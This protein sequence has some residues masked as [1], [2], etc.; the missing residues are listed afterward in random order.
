[1]NVIRTNEKEAIIIN[2]ETTRET[3]VT[4]PLICQK[5]P[6]LEEAM[7]K[8]IEKEE[9]RKCKIKDD[10]YDEI[11]E[12]YHISILFVLNAQLIFEDSDR[13]WMI[14]IQSLYSGNKK[15]IEGN[16]EQLKEIVIKKD[17]Y[18]GFSGHFIHYESTDRKGEEQNSL[19]CACLVK[20]T[21]DKKYL[22]E[23]RLA[24][25]ISD[26]V[27]IRCSEIEEEVRNM[28][29]GKELQEVVGKGALKELNPLTSWR[30]AREFRYRLI[31]EL[32]RKSLEI[33]I[34]KSGGFI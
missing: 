13:E 3:L 9:N 32:T 24:Y 2:A 12:S 31:E 23:I 6:V 7:K 28:K 8:I 20:L 33:S 19:G 21:E 34:T 25:T 15:S 22:E 29:V 30:A 1:M 27:P 10:I 17:D 11:Q 16:K 26:P 5:I 18:I 4:H 14:P